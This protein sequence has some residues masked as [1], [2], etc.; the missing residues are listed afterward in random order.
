[1]A[2]PDGRE[3]VLKKGA[4]FWAVARAT[5]ANIIIQAFLTDIYECLLQRRLTTT[6]EEKGHSVCI[7]SYVNSTKDRE[8]EENLKITE[9]SN[10]FTWC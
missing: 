9:K 8:W 5:S 1:M 10:V 3:K 7:H 6:G 4:G 2:N